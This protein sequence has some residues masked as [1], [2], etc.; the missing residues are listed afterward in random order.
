MKKISHLFSWC[1]VESNESEGKKVLL[2]STPSFLETKILQWHQLLLNEDL[3]NF[4]YHNDDKQN[5]YLTFASNTNHGPNDPDEWTPQVHQT[6]KALQ[7]F[8]NAMPDF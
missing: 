8:G 2:L 5:I 6:E 3:D 4:Y 1:G 7:A